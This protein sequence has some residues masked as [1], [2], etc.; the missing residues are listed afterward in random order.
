M[1]ADAEKRQR[2]MVERMNAMIS[3]KQEGKFKGFNTIL[4]KLSLS[5]YQ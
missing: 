3:S 5:G 1:L 2:L 4:G